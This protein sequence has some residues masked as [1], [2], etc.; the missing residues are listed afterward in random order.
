MYFFNSGTPDAT[1]T[2][3]IVSGGNGLFSLDATTG[4]VRTAGALDRETAANYDVVV[5]ATD[6]GSSPNP[7]VSATISFTITDVND[8]PPAC[9]PTVFVGK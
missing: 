4:I 1:V 8:E 6:G 3:A 5:T 9:S 2:F 7:A